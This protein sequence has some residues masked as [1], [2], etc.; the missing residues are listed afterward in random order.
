MWPDL[1]GQG[2]LDQQVVN[3]A[4]ENSGH[5][6][7]PS[8]FGGHEQPGVYEEDA[9]WGVMAVG[10]TWLSRIFRRKRRLRFVT[11]PDPST[12]TTNSS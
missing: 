1:V 11:Q 7:S 8:D 3:A 12:F 4:W 10:T 6:G 9:A 5:E 2:A